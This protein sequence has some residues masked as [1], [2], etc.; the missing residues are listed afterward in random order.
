M[1]DCQYIRP[2]A[3]QV[4]DFAAEMQCEAQSIQD[5]IGNMLRWFDEN[6][7]YSRLNAPYVPLQRSDLNV[8]AMRSGTCG[9]YANLI[10]S[11]LTCLGYRAAYAYVTRDCYGDPQ[12]H[13]CAA[14]EADGRWVLIDATRPYRKWMGF[15]CPH[16]EYE[17]LTAQEFETR[18]KAEEALQYEKARAFGDIRLAGLLYAPWVFEDTVVNTQDRLESVFYLLILSGAHACTLYVY[19][20]EYDIAAGKIPIMV[21]IQPSKEP[22]YQFSTQ[23]AADM[24]DDAQW[25]TGYGAQ[26]IPKELRT[27]RLSRL[28]GSLGRNLRNV[29]R[30]VEEGIRREFTE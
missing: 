8:L 9:D 26:D 5:L 30:V 14:C 10:V 28:D 15:D 1:D 18:M 17:L 27:P 23:Q 13:I 20:I 21:T 6:I 4:I 7:A 29:V 16:Q 3:P 12:D 25:G 19:Y 24:W 11:A 22:L 2:E